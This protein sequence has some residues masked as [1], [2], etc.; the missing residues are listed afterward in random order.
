MYCS[1]FKLSPPV[2]NVTPFP[3]STIGF[4]AFP[5]YSITTNFGS[6]LEPSAT[7]S[8]PPIF[9]FLISVFPKIVTCMSVPFAAFIAAFASTLG[10][11]SPP[12]VLARRRQAF[13]S[14][15]IQSPVSAPFF[16]AAETFPDTITSST[17]RHPSSGFVLY[18]TNSKFASPK[19]FARSSA[20]SPL[21]RRVNFSKSSNRITNFFTLF[22]L[23]MTI[24]FLGRR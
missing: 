14:S 1:G 10:V 4:S 12:G 19:F 8:I 6:S 22:A 13:I 21:F 5:L 20:S 16:T 15:A 24:I 18:S 11:I 17:N 7:P 2:S 23:A 9:N 3:T